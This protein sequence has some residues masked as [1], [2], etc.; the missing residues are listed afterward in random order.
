MAEAALSSGSAGI[1]QL[2]FIFS[3]EDTRE[4]K[5]LKQTKETRINHEQIAFKD[6][7]NTFE[8]TQHTDS[9]SQSTFEK[10][11]SINDKLLEASDG[12]HWV[13]EET[14]ATTIATTRGKR[15]FGLMLGTLAKCRTELAHSTDSVKRRE[16]ADQ[17]VLEKL[18][19]E[20]AELKRLARD[21][22]DEQRA[23]VVTSQKVHKRNFLETRGNTGKPS[24]FYLPAILTDAQ[25]QQ[26]A[27][28]D[29]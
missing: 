7:G 3:E 17:R 18:R 2:E 8:E 28:T 23:Q 20:R 1:D 12:S 24:L 14:Q 11:Q 10:S 27:S 16:A 21:R 15:L 29:S 6:S 22:L 25:V 13:S 26:L 5:E 19:L 4:N 9:N